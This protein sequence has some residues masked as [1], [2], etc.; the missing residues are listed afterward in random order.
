MLILRQRI[1]LTHTHSLNLHRQRSP[2]NLTI[3][4]QI[5]SCCLKVIDFKFVDLQSKILSHVKKALE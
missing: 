5:K 2:A 4:S 3:L 1:I